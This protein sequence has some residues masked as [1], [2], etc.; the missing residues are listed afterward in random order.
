MDKFGKDAL[1][2]AVAVNIAIFALLGS[3]SF[4]GCL[5]DEAKPKDDVI[6]PMDFTVVTE[7]NAADVLAEAP[8]AAAKAKPPPPPKAK[9]EP[10]PEPKPQPKPKPEPKPTPAPAPKPEPKPAPKAEPK[11]EVKKEPEKPK[12]KATSAKDI[13]KGKRVGPVT[14]GR[15]DRTRAPT[16]KALSAAEIQQLLNAGARPGNRNQVPP[17]EASRCSG[18]IQQVF[19]EACTEELEVSPTGRVPIL[20]VTFGAGG[21]VRGI[22]VA[23]SSG[24]RAFDAQVLTTCSQV[25]RVDGLSDVFL[26]KRGYEVEIRM[27]VLMPR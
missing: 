13:K 25:K 6:I 22:T 12:W 14:S 5:S 9:P 27:D 26:R 10:K 21:T 1:G 23:E 18:I 24:D 15:K 17:N 7:E 19:Y 4:G 3:I 20:K 11:Q 8:N 16:A 2:I